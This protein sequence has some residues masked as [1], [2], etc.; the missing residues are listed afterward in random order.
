V[1]SYHHAPAHQVAYAAPAYGH[2]EHGTSEQ[3]IVRSAHGTVSQISKAVDTPHSSVR[4]YDTRIIND[5]YKAVSYQPATTYLQSA[6]VLT[7]A[8]VAQPLLTKTVSHV[9]QP[10]AYSQPIAY[11]QPQYVHAQQQYAHAAPVLAKSVHFSPAAEVAHVSFE[12][13]GTNYGW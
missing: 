12:G 1:S 7:K 10:V 4:K 13:F 5:G 11:A 9:A 8:V 6:P 2:Y 3:N